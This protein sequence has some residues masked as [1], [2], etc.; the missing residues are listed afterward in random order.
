[1]NIT[2]GTPGPPFSLPDQ[3]GKVHTLHDYQGQW[4]LLYFYPKDATPGCTKEAC[5]FRDAYAGLREAGLRILGISADSV[6]SHER[7]ATRHE[8]PFPLLADPAKGTIRAYG[9]NG[10][11]GVKRI[12]FLID[13]A[14]NIAKAYPKVKPTEHPGEVLADLK[15]LQQTG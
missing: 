9:A 8:L 5:T 11:F 7:F 6:E 10:G 1:M 12:S 4:V 14:G 3:H 13:P 15:E 2:P